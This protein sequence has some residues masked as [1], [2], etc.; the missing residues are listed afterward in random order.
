MGKITD[1]NKFRRKNFK[2]GYGVYEFDWGV[3]VKEE[4]TNMWTRVFLK[5]DGLEID[6]KGRPALLHENGIEF[7][8]G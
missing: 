1:I 5:D 4:K 6:L 2:K 3:G 7:I 8:K